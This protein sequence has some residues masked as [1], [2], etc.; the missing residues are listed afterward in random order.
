MVAKAKASP[1]GPTYFLWLI[2]VGLETGAQLALKAASNAGTTGWLNSVS[3]IVNNPWFLASIS[4]D[5]ANL[6]VWLAILR[7]HE[8]SVAVPLS[9]MTYFAVLLA[10]AFLLHEPVHGVQLAGLILVG[11]GV[12]LVSWNETSCDEG[13][14]DSGDARVADRG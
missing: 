8:L 7:R 2:F 13:G 1:D 12:T 3:P 14:R 11:I 4:C 9:S 10:T 6:I 5:A